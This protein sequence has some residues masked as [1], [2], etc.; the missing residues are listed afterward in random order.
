MWKKADLCGG[1][2]GLQNDS[3]ASL[4][5]EA[6][7]ATDCVQHPGRTLS[8]NDIVQKK[9]TDQFIQAELS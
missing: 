3:S 6:V 2:L 4:P 7:P 1:N 5:F 9:I 8:S